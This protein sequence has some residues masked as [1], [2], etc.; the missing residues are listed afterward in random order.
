MVTLTFCSY[1]ILLWLDLLD[2]IAWAKQLLFV[3]PV[4]KMNACDKLPCQLRGEG[5]YCVSENGD[6]GEGEGLAWSTASCS[7]VN[8]SLILLSV[9]KIRK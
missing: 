4:E 9:R 2:F 1:S 5:Q 6:M 8:R 7:C 3:V